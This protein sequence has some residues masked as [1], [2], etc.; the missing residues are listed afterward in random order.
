MPADP[1]LSVSYPGQHSV[2]QFQ[3]SAFSKIKVASEASDIA[4]GDV[5]RRNKAGYSDLGFWIP[6]SR[7]YI[8]GLTN[9]VKASLHLASL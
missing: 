2:L 1:Q 6:I 7:N 8:D 5:W 9:S 4:E 3:L